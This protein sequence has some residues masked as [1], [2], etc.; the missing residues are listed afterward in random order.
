[1]AGLLRSAAALGPWRPGRPGVPPFA[2]RPPQA[3]ARP[4]ASSHASDD[5]L[6]PARL[7]R[8]TPQ[9][10]DFDAPRLL[11]GIRAASSMRDS[12]KLRWPALIVVSL[13]FTALA[14]TA[15]AAGRIDPTFHAARV[16]RHQ[17]TLVGLM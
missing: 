7:R 15:Q 4:P 8:H 9:A 1:R 6:R 10:R 3:C 14:P 16:L 17:D 2:A 11:A 5:N 13:A 12:I